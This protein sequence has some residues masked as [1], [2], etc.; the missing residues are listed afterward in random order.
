MQQAG[1]EMGF[2]VSVI[3]LDEARAIYGV[4]VSPEGRTVDWSATRALRGP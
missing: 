1:A 2:G 3:S 4:V